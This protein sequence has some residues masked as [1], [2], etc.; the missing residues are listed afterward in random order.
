MADSLTPL[1]LDAKHEYTSRLKDI[2][3]QRFF[4]V[5]KH[6]YDTCEDDEYIIEFQEKLRQIPYWS[7]SQVSIESSSIVSKHPYFE[8]LMAAVI[9][10]YVKVLSSIR[11]SEVKPNVQLKLP[12]VDEFVHELYKQM[13]GIIYANPFVFESDDVAGTFDKMADDAIERSIRRLIPF[14]DILESYLSAPQAAPEVQETVTAPA[15]KEES[16]SSSDDDDEDIEIRTDGLHQFQNG[17]PISSSDD[18]DVDMAPSVQ[19]PTMPQ[20][21][22]IPDGGATV[23]TVH[24]PVGQVDAPTHVHEAQDPM[25]SGTQPQAPQQ[26]VQAPQPMEPVRAPPQQLVPG[27]RDLL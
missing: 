9:V 6:M 7:S 11:L 17:D 24:A 19:Q 18:D 15:Q 4:H 20:S 27:G 1:L 13:A 23:Q 26:F 8:N 12:S 14:D 10:T 25:S 21:F 2:I 5:F 3:E 16:E 22:P